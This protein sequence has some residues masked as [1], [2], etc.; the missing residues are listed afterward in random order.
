LLDRISQ[1]HTTLLTCTFI[2][3]EPLIK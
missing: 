2:C 1:E 3:N